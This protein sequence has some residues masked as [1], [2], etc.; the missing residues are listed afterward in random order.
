MDPAVFDWNKARKKIFFRNVKPK[1]H[2]NSSGHE[3]F[4]WQR[5]FS[6]MELKTIYQNR[7][8]EDLSFRKQMWK[9]L[10]SDF[11]QKY[12]PD[13]ATVLELGC[14]Y[15]EFINHI[16]AAKKFGVDLNPDSR[17]YASPEVTVI[18]AKSA[19]LSK[20]FNN[21]SV[22]VVFMSNFLEHLERKEITQTLAEA[23]RCLKKGGVLL[24]LQPNIRYLVHEY[25]RF[26][27]HI[28]PI[29]DRAICELLLS[30]QFSSVGS[31]SRF[32]PYTTKGRLPKST[33]LLKL[34]LK[35]PFLF[36]IFGKQAFIKAYK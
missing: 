20:A 2:K 28:T 9:V 32:L 10:C 23:H 22:D 5:K 35:L 34:Y 25:W 29:D 31:L 33:L 7:F 24:I 27:D 26:I 36:R 4:D 17:K 30:L 21:E 11:F 14:G 6:G 13:H 18:E 12:I 8:E 1:V 16:K 3:K 15:C 19:D